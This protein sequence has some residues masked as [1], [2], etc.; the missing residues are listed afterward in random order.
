M[1]LEVLQVRLLYLCDILLY[2]GERIRYVFLAPDSGVKEDVKNG[3]FLD[4]HLIALILDSLGYP[5]GLAKI[6]TVR[7][8]SPIVLNRY[9]MRGPDENTPTVSC[10]HH[11]P[12]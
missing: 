12:Q 1:L 4:E 2:V 10:L 5:S 9:I 8:G 3:L 6:N 11:V 7:R